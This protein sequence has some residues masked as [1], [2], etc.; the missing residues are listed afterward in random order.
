M[1]SGSHGSEPSTRQRPGRLWQAAIGLAILALALTVFAWQQSE[2]DSGPL[3]AV[4]AAAERTQGQP[5]GRAT[6]QAI[7][8]PAQSESFTITGRT[9]FDSEGRSRA[10][11]TFPRPGSGGSAKMQ[12]IADGTIVYM[13]SSQFDSLPK[14]REWVALDVSFG[15]ELNVLPANGDAKGELQLLEAV[16]GDIQKLGEEDVRGTP[17]TRYRGAVG[18]SE[19]AEWLREAGAEKLASYVEKEGSPMQVE[20]WI[21]AND[22]V[23]R[24]GFVQSQPG[25]KGEGPTTVNMR[26]DFFDFGLEPEID[27]PDSSEVFDAT[28]LAQEELG[29]SSGE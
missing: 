4:A 25:E 16:S 14:G 12:V 9:V 18:V 28:A 6:M 2:G 20:A 19:Q 13:R 17:T 8:S 23:R 7:V 22:L 29:I 3:N 1:T 26:M 10:V 24:M 11:L 5:G 21:D 15:Q 27:A